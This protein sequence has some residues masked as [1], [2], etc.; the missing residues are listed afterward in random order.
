MARWAGF[1]WGFAEGL[2]FFIV[3]DVYVMFATLFAPRAGIVAWLFS[4]AGS[5][6]AVVV[7]H[8]FAVTW[9]LDYLAFLV[10]VP[11]I[12]AGLIEHVRGKLAAE[13][14]PYSPLLVLGGVPLKVYAALAFARGFPLGSVLLWTVFARIAR[15]A[16]SV[17]LAG[18]TRLAFRRSLDEHPN[19]WCVVFICAWVAFYVFYFVRMGWF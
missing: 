7:I 3:P 1:S 16:P 14:L 11:G 17:A 19:V 2:F 5:I 13:G 4:I 9:G 18:A 6:A 10:R 12:S 15:M 8:L